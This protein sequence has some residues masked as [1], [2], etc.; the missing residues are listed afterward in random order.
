[1]NTISFSA[2]W[3]NKLDCKY[4]TTIRIYNPLKHKTGKKVDI[5]LKKKLKNK[6][7]IIGVKKGYIKDLG[8]YDCYL[9]T[10]YSKQ[11]TISIMLKMYPK[12]NFKHQLVALVLL[13]KIEPPKPVQKELFT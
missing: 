5:L 8:A 3:N 12:I 6:A 10:G 2:N 4:F 1:M 7:Q 9:D 11:E 13:K